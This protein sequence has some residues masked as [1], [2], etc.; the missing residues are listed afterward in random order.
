[1]LVAGTRESATLNIVL[2]VIKLIA[3]AAFVAL[4]LPA[5]N[6]ANFEPFMPYG[7]GTSGADGE[8]RGVM[9]AAAIIFF[10]FYG[11]DA[12]ATSAEEA[13][14]PG[15][16]LTIG[17]VGSMVACRSST[18]SS[19]PPRSARC[20]HQLRQQPRA[21][22]PGAARAR[23][24]GRRHYL[25]VAAV[26]ALPS[27]ILVLMYGQSRIFFVMAR[28]GLLP[29]R[30]QGVHAPARRRGS[31][32][33]P[34][35]GRRVAGFVRL[36]EIAALANAGTLLAF[37]AVGACMM[38]LRRR[39]PDRRGCSAALRLYGRHLCD[40]RLPLSVLQPAA[41]DQLWFLGAQVV[42][43]AHLL[44]STAR[45]AAWPAHEEA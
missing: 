8:K 25:A 7:F 29:R 12:V 16:D 35:R 3:L 27:V 22:G 34:R 26:I 45:G 42:G 41:E 13:K 21:A 33:S 2:V 1:M 18:C 19:R 36:D 14:N 39:A 43:F 30:W 20:L 44:R 9:A 17:I 24:A 32:S 28:D 6:A 38:V 11:F 31:P 40:P 37:I 23:P 15:R 10:A 5:F 4:A